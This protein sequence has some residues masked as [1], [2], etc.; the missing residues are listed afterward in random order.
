M[1]F[2]DSSFFIG[3]ADK[4]D[5]WHKKAL[6]VLKKIEE[7][8]AVTDLVISESVTSIGNRSGGK[9]GKR[10]FDFFADNCQIEYVDEDLL[11]E[12][13]KIFLKFDGGLSVADSVSVAIMGQRRISKIVSFDSDFDK[14]KGIRRIR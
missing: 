14:V 2:A 4:R 11:Q 7:Q 9:A 5:N 3:L 1:I 12:G 13:M 6:K 8:M 10:L